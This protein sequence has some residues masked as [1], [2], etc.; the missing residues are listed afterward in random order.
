MQVE[1]IAMKL[2]QLSRMLLR[3]SIAV[4]LLWALPALA[5]DQDCLA[6]HGEPGMKSESGKS[7]Q[8]DAAK[9]KGSVHGDLGCTTCHVGVKEYQHPK[10]LRMPKCVTCHEEES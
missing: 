4:A 2:A 3:L 1:G 7:L 8:V 10:P 6:C 9:H 5:S